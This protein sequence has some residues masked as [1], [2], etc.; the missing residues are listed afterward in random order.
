MTT[1]PTVDRVWASSAPSGNIQDPD[2]YEAGKV[3]RGWEAEIPPF[4][5]FNWI[6]RRND[7]LKIS[8]LERGIAAWGNDITYKLGALSYNDADNYIYV[9]LKENKGIQPDMDD[10]V[11]WERSAIQITQDEWNQLEALVNNHIANKSNPHQVT[12]AQVGAYTKAEA[13]GKVKV[14]QDNLDQHEARVDNPHK[15]TATQAGAVPITGGTYTGQVNFEANKTEFGGGS[16]ESLSSSFGLR[17]G[18]SFL[19]I[20]PNNK[21]YFW[22]DVN[23]PASELL[24][25]E[26]FAALKLQHQ[27]D[28][29]V[30]TPDFYMPLTG[31][32]NIYQGTGSTTFSRASTATYINKQGVLTVAAV[33]EPRFE[34]E[35]LLMEGASTNLIPNSNGLSEAGLI[36][37]TSDVG[38]IRTYDVRKQRSVTSEGINFP[39]NPSGKV[40]ASVWVKA[41]SSD[42]VTIGLYSGQ[43][44]AAS[45]ARIVF[46]QGELT[47]SSGLFTIRGLSNSEWTKV[48]VYRSSTC[49]LFY[50]YP[51]TTG[52]ATVGRGI[53]LQAA[54]VEAL[55]FATSYIPTDGAAVT[56]A[57]DILKVD[58]QVFTNQPKEYTVSCKSQSYLTK[59]NATVFRKGSSGNLIGVIHYD[60]IVGNFGMYGS[61]GSGSDTPRS[62]EMTTYT[63]C[64]PALAETHLYVNGLLDKV[65]TRT[66]T[67]DAEGH[68]YLGAALNNTQHLYGHLKDFR[69]WNSA[70]TPEQISTI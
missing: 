40:T 9:C 32:T 48:E 70:L 42:K 62:I 35:G 46:G 60:N 23:L 29:N 58:T 1:R 52:S 68:L 27:P 2:T 19:A 20:N 47:G 50:I 11:N 54:Q 36:V 31:D 34:K 63:I 66:S 14:V 53:F 15:V 4:Q 6:L 25:E 18:D 65:S 67:V 30:P 37:G 49:N 38:G 59:G 22:D 43:W 24:Y 21:P 13:D 33:D 5:W 45:T 55:P 16:I 26:N 39:F 44:D 57:A 8:L 3:V 69:V 17:K 56:R 41:G 10:G 61:F 51:D 7:E 28:Y 64:N 12:A